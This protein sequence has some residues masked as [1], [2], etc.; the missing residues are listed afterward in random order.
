MARKSAVVWTPAMD[1][2]IGL[3]SDAKTGACLGVHEQC[4][5]TRRIALGV[6]TY[7]STRAAVSVECAN[8]GKATPRKQRAQRRSKRLFCSVEC[9]NA[10]QKTRDS[11]TLR[12]GPGWKQRRSEIRARD[13]LCRLCGMTPEANQSALHVHHL[14]PYKY[15]GTN[16][17][18]NLIALCSSCH[19][20]VEAMTAKALA[21]IA[22]S[23]SLE[24]SLVTLTVDGIVRWRESAPGVGSRIQTG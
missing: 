10:G 8:C 19:H 20:R 14:V 2:L 12:Y 9:A 13:R 7:R 24:G 22:I 1:L 6:P 16:H 11:D 5:R 3:Q 18:S 4:V 21:S 15:G 23:V 17:P